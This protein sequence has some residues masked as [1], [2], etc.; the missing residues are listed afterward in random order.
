MAYWYAT[1]YKTRERAEKALEELFAVGDVS[2]G[3]FPRIERYAV[4]DETTVA[5]WS[6]RYGIKLQG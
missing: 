5:R 3:E 2:E 6:Y 1:G 4:L